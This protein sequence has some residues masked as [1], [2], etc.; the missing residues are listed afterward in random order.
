MLKIDDL[1]APVN[2]GIPHVD[3]A[4]AQIQKLV[5]EQFLEDVRGQS[6]VDSMVR[7]TG[8]R[9]EIDGL[10]VV[11]TSAGLRVHNSYYRALAD[12]T[13][14][15]IGYFRP[16]PDTIDTAP[17]LECWSHRDRR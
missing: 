3:D 4:W 15:G 8:E 12:M 13:L 14:F 10:Q 17:E 6:I 7:L 1:L 2:I 11:T 16:G 9:G 5:K